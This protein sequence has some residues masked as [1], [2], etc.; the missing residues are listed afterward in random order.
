MARILL[1]DD[2][3]FMRATLKK[4]LSD[5]GFDIV[6]EAENGK[7]AVERY[8]ELK[9]DLVMLDITMP[10]KTGLE[11]LEEI[12]KLD[13]NATVIMCTAI[14]Q[15]RVVAQALQTGAKDYIIKPFKPDKVVDAVNKAISR[16]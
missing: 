7:L 9:P 6:G 2:T 13:P 16:S 11:A 8:E 4:V 5:A 12:M 15:E 10:V 3:L 1:A 14:G